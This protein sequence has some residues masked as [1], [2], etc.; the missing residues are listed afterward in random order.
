MKRSAGDTQRAYTMLEIKAVNDEGD[1]RYI[2]GIASTPTVDRVGDIVRPKGAKYKLPMPLLW[3]HNRHAPVGNVT[4]AKADDNGIKFRAEFANILE[5]GKLKDRVDEAWQSVKYGLVRAMSIGFKILDFEPIDPK[6]PFGGW[7][8]KEWDWLELSAVTIP[9]N[10]D[11]TITTVR[12]IVESELAAMG[13]K[14]S[15]GASAPRKSVRIKD[16]TMKKS[17]AEQISAFEAARASKAARMN[18]IMDASGEKGETLDEAQDQEFKDLE[19]EVE[20]IDRHLKRLRTMEALN[21]STAIEVRGQ[22]QQDG[23]ESRDSER[24]RTRVSVVG[25]N[26]PQGMRFVRAVIA[27]I[28][29]EKMHQNPAEIAKA[30]WPDCPEVVDFLNYKAAVAA[31]T[32]TNTTWAAP[33]VVAQNLPGEFIE[34]LRPMTIIGRINGFRRVP[35]NIKVPRQTA[36]ATVNWVG[37]TKVKPLSALAFDQ[38]SLDFTKVAGIIPLSEELVRFSSPSAEAVV[39]QDLAAAIV[40]LIDRDFVDPTKTLQAT[41]SPAS[42]TNGVT[43]VV[44]TGINSAAFRADIQA[45]MAKFFDNNVGLANAVWIMTQTQALAIGM[46]LNSLGAQLYP[47]IGPTGGTLFGIPVVASEGIPDVGGSPANGSY[48][49]LANAGEIM[50]ADDGE[51]TIDVSR[52]ASLQMD[53]T[54]DSPAVAATVLVSLWQHNLIAVKAE[55]FINWQ[56]RR[57]EAVQYISAAKYVGG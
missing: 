49:I 18:E 56:K 36:G 30:R 6:E 13:D 26:L 31:G 19:Q 11:C 51:V 17:I 48:I 1:Q 52:E 2:E 10:A 22:S 14:S 38:V 16:Q 15:A 12:S 23:S 35:F 57:A 40:Q 47:T 29:S 55:R 24:A 53:S 25:D 42:I 21:K 34:Y 43:P 28:L 50:L 3:Q 54:P 8:I 27:S 20:E 32:T 7:D 46:M 5:P 39:R 9:A 41:V 45:L 4:F 37:E 44:A 33:L